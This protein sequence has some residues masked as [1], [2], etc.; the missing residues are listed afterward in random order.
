LQKQTEVLAED[1]RNQ[2]F[3]AKAFH[4]G[5]SSAAK[6][7]LQDEF[8]AHENLIIVA[9]IAFGMGI[10]KS[11]IRNVIHFNIPSSIE[12]Y[13]QEIGR[14]GRDGKISK[15]LFFVCG[16]DLHLR[17]IFARGDLPSRES[18]QRLLGE[19]CNPINA[20]LKVG[21]TIQASLY[22]QSRAYDIRPTT[23]SNIYA[24]LELHFGLFRAIT[25]MYT[26]YSYKP[27]PSVNIMSSD[28]SPAALAIKSYATTAKIITSV[29]ITAAS[30][31][32]NLP[33]ADLVR[34]LNEW[35][36]ARAI[37]L[38]TA[39]VL[40]IYRITK[41]LPSTP[42]DVKA[43][44]R[45]LYA[46]LESREQKDLNR[47][48]EM[49]NLITGS[50]CFA[51]SL[52]QH[53]GDDL[54]DPTNNECGHCTWC[55]THKAVEMATPA[56]K[57]FDMAAFD[58]VLEATDVRDDARLLAR[59]AFGISSPRTTA[60]GLGGN[61]VFGSM[62]EC[63]FMDLVRRFEAVCCRVA[64]GSLPAPGSQPKT[65]ESS[66]KR[67]TSSSRGRSPSRARGRSP[68]RA[69]NTYTRTLSGGSRG[70]GG[71]SRDGW[72]GN[73]DRDMPLGASFCTHG[74]GGRMAR[75]WYGR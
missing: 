1:L 62:S 68:A 33:R 2:R 13:S 70:A 6:M 32:R 11:N 20:S 67:A 19:I 23:L 56:S 47:T 7:A 16:D 28:K 17:E 27:G 64:Q 58:K 21:E 49:L 74:E 61:A 36:D 55:M 18:V 9:T 63:G 73:R 46:E 54:P 43:I 75:D 26:K 48:D 57:P 12:S 69:R 35:N 60:L 53:F 71:G 34:K 31:G 66:R 22:E 38:T 29:D 25:P 44:S 50:K 40:N 41:Q 3:K 5:M 39:G 72:R 14:A 24:Q 4:A 15:C 10:D 8:M 45:E 42:S 37:E 65:P 52:A 30:A 59:V 51:K